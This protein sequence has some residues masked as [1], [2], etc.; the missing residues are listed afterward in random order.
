M[1]V[2]KISYVRSKIDRAAR[3]GCS[4]ARRSVALI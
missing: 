2:S 1:S 4:A 3:I